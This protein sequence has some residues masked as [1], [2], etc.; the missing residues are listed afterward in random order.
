M[1]IANNLSIARKKFVYTLF[2]LVTCQG[3]LLAQSTSNAFKGYGKASYIPSDKGAF[4]RTWLLLGPVNVSTVKEPDEAQQES[5]FKND[6]VTTVS[7][8]AGKPVSAMTV[9]QQQ[10]EWKQVSSDGDMID[11]DRVYA[12]KDYV[13][14]YA[15][16]EINSPEATNVILALGS[17]DGVKVWHNGKL[18]HNNWIPRPTNKDEDLVPLHLVKG[19]NQ[20]LLKVQDMTGGWSFVARLLDKKAMVNLANAAAGSGNVGKLQVLIDGGADINGQNEMGITPLIAAKVGGRDAVVQMLLKKGAKDITVP[21]AEML[22]DNMYYSLKEKSSPGVAVLVADDSRILYEKA[23]GY[24]DIKNKIAATPDTKF[25]IG[26]VTKQFTAAAILKLQE[27]NLLS[28]NDKLSKFIPDFPRGDEVTIHH[29]LTHTSG[30][31]SY[32]N[33]PDFIDKVT[34]TISPDSLISSIKNDPYDFNPGEQLRYN[35]SGYF[36]LG[37]IINKVSGKSYEQYLKETF[38]NPLQMNN[39]GIHYAGIKLEKK[40][41][42]IV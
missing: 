33:K 42:V 19:S 22:V 29:L 3:M 25:R 13:Y 40:R 4:M 39:T 31:H 28:V 21:S 2:V 12:G 38:F 11:L 26:S 37:Y 15:L 27:N 16:A 8:S 6:A 7:V 41:R 35:N 5:V 9:N 36:L 30:I 1:N 18:V 24:A 14:A 17:D 20:L 32:T 34:K 10:L 23:Y